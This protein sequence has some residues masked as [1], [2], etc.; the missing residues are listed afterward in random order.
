VSIGRTSVIYFS[1]QVGAAVMSPTCIQ[2]P[3]VPVSNQLSLLKLGRFPEYFQTFFGSVTHF[4]MDFDEIGY[5][6][7][8][9]FLY[10]LKIS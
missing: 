1:E 8:T 2:R 5:L 7:E 6:P 4:S 10:K 3:D 9:A